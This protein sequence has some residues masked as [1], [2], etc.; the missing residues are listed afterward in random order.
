[1]TAASIACPRCNRTSHH[2]TDVREGYCG[3][4]HDWTAGEPPATPPT[5]MECG[6][7]MLLDSAFR[8]A[9]E[10]GETPAMAA[11]L[12]VVL[13]QFAAGDVTVDPD[14][15]WGLWRCYACDTATAEPADATRTRTG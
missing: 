11:L 10:D 6:K 2:P 8:L 5:C 14:E 15:L 4:C 1:V 3:F 13:A 9:H 12:D 7:A